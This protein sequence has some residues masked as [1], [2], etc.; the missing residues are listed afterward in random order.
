M[1]TFTKRTVTIQ[2]QA[3][4]CMRKLGISE[5]E[6]LTV[7]NEWESGEVDTTDPITSNTLATDPETAEKIPAFYDLERD[8]PDRNQIINVKYS[9]SFKKWRGKTL[10]IAVVHW[11]C[12]R[13]SLI[14]QFSHDQQPEDRD[15]LQPRRKHTIH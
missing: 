3:R 11:V 14:A 5:D 9:T 2:P 8:F 13:P 15:W 6:V 12:V 1:A 7:I 4:D 10:I